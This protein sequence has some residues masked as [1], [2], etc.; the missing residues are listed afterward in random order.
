MLFASPT[1]HSL[2][3]AVTKPSTLP[4]QQPSLEGVSTW[5]LALTITCLQPLPLHSSFHTNAKDFVIAISCPAVFSD[6]LSL[7]EFDSNDLR[8]TTKTLRYL[9]P[10]YSCANSISQLK[11]S[12]YRAF[13]EYSEDLQETEGTDSPYH[14]V[15][16]HSFLC[17]ELPLLALSLAEILCFWT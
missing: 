14:C 15:C 9:T 5:K 2:L 11:L 10:S 13:P 4:L 6:S 3:P 7:A 16:P 17:P 8:W 1:P 12:T